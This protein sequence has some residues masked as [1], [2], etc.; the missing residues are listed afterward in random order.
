MIYNPLAGGL[1]SGKIKS[2][3]IPSD[4]RFSNTGGQ[5]E[6]YRARYFQDATFDALRMIEDVAQKHSLTM[7]E[8]GLRWVAHH[9]ALRID[10]GRDGIIVGVSSLD[11][12][13][14]N[15]ADLEKGP[16]PDEVVKVLDKAW[17]LTSPTTP[18]I[19][20]WT[21]NIPMIPTRPCF[22]QRLWLDRR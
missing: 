5:G 13:K 17:L 2:K 7:L 3:D 16:L 6:R 4:G 20:I 12:L 8:I 11:Q 21:S 14:G 22:S 1:F 10:D 19:G 18:T 9:S 15:L